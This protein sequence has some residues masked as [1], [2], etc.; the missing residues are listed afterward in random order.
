[1]W[2]RCRL[3]HRQG[4][5]VRVTMYDQKRKEKKPPLPM[6]SAVLILVRVHLSR[7]CLVGIYL[8]LICLRQATNPRCLA[9]TFSS[10]NKEALTQKGQVRKL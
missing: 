6:L 2:W 3:D 9:Y 4:K 7:L 8:I 10:Y 1:M 5:G